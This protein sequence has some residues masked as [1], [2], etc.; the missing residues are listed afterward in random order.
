M[1]NPIRRWTL[2]IAL[3]AVPVDSTATQPPTFDIYWVD[4]EGGAAT[5]LV[6]PT[7]E[8]LLVD[9]GYPTDDDR[10][11]KRIAAAA[12]EAGLSR[13]DYLVITHYHR[14]HVGGLEALAELIPIA[15]GASTTGTRP[16]QATSSGSTRISASARTSGS[17]WRRARRSRSDPWRST[18]S[19]RT[20]A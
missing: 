16:K 18:S 3:L 11:A 8:S 9:T 17:S 2:L 20:A 13:I 10:D 1:S 5:L 15:S 19:R 14:D 12:A 6:S 7:G 4:V